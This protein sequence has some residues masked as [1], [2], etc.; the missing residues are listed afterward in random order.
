MAH[1]NEDLVRKGYAAFQS[2]DMA[3]LNELFADDIVWHAPGRNQLSGDFR[4]REAVLATLQKTFE[5]TGGT[6]KLDI[7][8]VL[9][10]DAHAV[11]LV[12]A[13]A[14]REGKTLEDNSVQV[15]HISD[16]KVTEQWLYPG[17]VYATD[18]FW[19]QG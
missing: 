15:F 16:G 8:E 13:N 6:F 14:Q 19:G 4:G 9:A 7:H 12:K 1:P 18:E 10:N 3:T 5:L 11:G 2:G 17:D